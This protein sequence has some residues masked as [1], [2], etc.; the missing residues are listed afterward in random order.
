MPIPALIRNGLLPP[1]NHACTLDELRLRFGMFQGSDRRTQLFKRLAELV[2]ELRR[3]GLF[4]AVVI[5]GSFAIAVAAPEDM[6]LIVGLRRDHDWS[7]DLGMRDYTL[8]SR[9]ALR[10]RFGFDVFL[11]TDGGKDY[12]RYVEFFG[13]V[14]EDTSARKGMMRIEL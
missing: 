10:R 13:R 5:D 8:V 3:S 1:G 9:S 6:D 14:R 7:A 4:S 2:T 12:E 11:A